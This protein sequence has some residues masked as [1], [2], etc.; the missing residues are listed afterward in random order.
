M[1]A[2][3]RRSL[4]LMWVALFVLSLLLQ[5]AS[6][7]AAPAVLAVHDEDFQLDG[8]AVDDVANPPDDWDNHP[9]ADVSIFI[10]DPLDAQ[11]DMIFTGGG[12]K[13][14]NDIDEWAWTFG[15]V[16]DK[17]NIAHAYA[18]L[19]DDIVYFGL[20]RYANNGDAQVGF[21]FLK[22]GL[23]LGDGTFA[24]PHAIG[25]LLVVSHFTNGGAI[26]TIDLFEWVGSGGSDG[27]IDLLGSGAVCTGAPVDDIGCAIANTG[28]EPAPWPYN[29]KFGDE[30]IFPPGS[31]FE[32][33]LDLASVFGGTVPC[34]SSFLV[35]TRSSQEPSAQLKDFANG[36]FNTCAPP[37]VETE[38]SDTAI[39][40][41]GSVTDTATLSGSD[42][43][44]SGT[45]DFFACGPTDAPAN[46]AGGTQVGG[47]VDVDTSANGGTATSASFTPTEPG[48]YCFRVQYTPDADS[49]Y[50]EAGHTNDSSECF[51]VLAADVN[52][53]KIANPE[54]PVS[55]GDE[56]GFDIT[57]S[58]DGDG[59][60]TGVELTDEL[61]EGVDWSNDA[62]TGDVD[63][64]DCE[65]TGAVGSQTLTCTDDS[66]AAG[67]AFSVHVFGDTDAA[68]CGTISNTA[69]VESGNDGGGEATATVDVLC[70]NVI[71]DK[72]P[73]AGVVN[74]GETATFTIEVT[75]E[76]PGAARDVTLTDELPAGIDWN[77]ESAACE[78]S[79]DVDS[80]VLECEFG[81]LAAGASVTVEVFGEATPESCGD[82]PNTASVAA[83]NEPAENT[84]D[85]SDSGEIDVTCAQ[86]GVTKTADDDVVSAG[87]QIGF[88]V[89]ITN[90]GDGQAEG[91]VFTDDLPGG[92]GIDW[93]IES[94]SSGWSISGSAPNEE[95]V[96]APTTL[97]MGASS[98]VHVVSDTTDAS[99][100]AYDNTATVTTTND[101]SD[102][103]SASTTV[104]CSELT[105][106]KAFTGN[107]GGIDPVLNVPL[108]KIGDT[109][110]Y[111]LTYTGDGPITNGVISDVLPIGLDFVEGSATSD[112]NFTF[113][114]IDEATRTLTW[115]TA[116]DV[117][118][119]SPSGSVNYNVVVLAAAAEEVQPLANVATI[120]S[121]ETEPDDDTKDVAVAPAPLGLTPPP[122]DALAPSATSSNAGFALMLILLA[123]AGLALT[124]GFITPVP[125]SVRR[126][127]RLG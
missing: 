110:S 113:V 31:F 38:V 42:G 28:D 53:V 71:V 99:C 124:I 105:I 30:G 66:M 65:I 123:V 61:P 90:N 62:P 50:L 67:D 83:S 48:F 44:V 112:A 34:F 1:S 26:S 78:I 82:L 4:T 43:P 79:G 94:S 114:G 37:V 125:E 8:N 64:V 100:A 97:A 84:E 25:D 3:S 24:P 17:D 29:P 108:A 74:A 80:E 118:L 86:I 119:D 46:C 111:T 55:A 109:L 14:I 76:G 58:N 101:G 104:V 11:L 2:R 36:D 95:L 45:V 106:V 51:Q 56:I 87:N 52:I 33:G 91:L 127:D 121:D 16:P 15:S 27:T 63:G 5:Y 120:D 10:D 57:V 81:N 59:T 117:T 40:L 107:T 73:D 13:D 126:R 9:G 88:V 54:G 116:A 85:N 60:A 39:D 92:P 6:F 93:E 69:V 77:E 75:N 115:Q 72:T 19:Y 20:D 18:A 41:G 103:S 47:S 35:E 122:T 23:T 32:G 70:P 49:Q 7:A 98:A 96:Y 89:T 12:S 21:W 102:E 22:N 68:D